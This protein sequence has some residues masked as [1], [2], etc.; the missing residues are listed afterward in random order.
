MLERLQAREH[1]ASDADA[2]VLYSQLAQDT[3]DVSWHRLDSSA[4]VEAVR[5]KAASLLRGHVNDASLMPMSSVVHSSG[6][7]G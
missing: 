1:D 2:A 4:S 3:G 7:A 5:E 6:C